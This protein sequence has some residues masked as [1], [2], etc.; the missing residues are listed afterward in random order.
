[1]T[2]K[3]PAKTWRVSS[4]DA[5]SV[6]NRT[7]AAAYSWVAKL[8]REMQLPATVYRWD[9]GWQLYERVEALPHGA[10]APGHVREA[11]AL[12]EDLDPPQPGIILGDCSCGATYSA[13]QGGDEY[14]ALEAAH[15]LHVTEV[16]Q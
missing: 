9:D 5:M 11:M 13:P 7:E 14:G 15:R 3:P 16:S 4:P 1:M 10:A 2:A 6:E 8:T 12:G